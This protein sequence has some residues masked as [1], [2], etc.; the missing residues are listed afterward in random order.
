MNFPRDQLL[1][2]A[3]LSADQYRRRSGR[4]LPDDRED[5]LHRGGPSDQIPEYAAKTQVVCESVSLL[6]TSFVANRA[7]QKDFEGTR[8]HGLFQKP[9]CLKVVDGGER[10]VHTAEAGE[11]DRRGEI[12]A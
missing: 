3:A 1:A 11:R 9:K 7:I 5:L 10:F 4:H 6:Q 2:C 12:S 8:F